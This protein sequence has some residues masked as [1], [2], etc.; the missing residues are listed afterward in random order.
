[1]REKGRILIV[2]DDESI[3]RSMKVIFE[4]KNYDADIVH[5]GQEAIAATKKRPYNL[6][7]I[8]IRLPDID[9]ITL[10][11][12]L[13]KMNA[14][15]GIIMITGYAS[16]ETAVDALNKGAAAYITK[17]LNMDE[18]LITVNKALEKQ[19]L[20]R[21][22]LRAEAALQEER[23]RAQ[24][25][26]D[27]AGVM[28]VSLDLDGTVT[29][30][31][32]RGCEIL[33]YDSKEI[34]GKDWFKTFIPKSLRKEVHRAFTSL[35][36]G[37][38]EPVE[39][40]ENPV[41]TKDGEER[42][43]AWHSSVLTDESG[44]IAGTLSSG[45]DV[46]ERKEAN[47]QLRVSER[48]HKRLFETSQDG[49]AY[50]DLN[51]LFVDVNQGFLNIV[52]YDR[53]ELLSMTY[54]DITPE[55]W[56]GAEV[57][58]YQT[59]IGVRGYSEEYEKEFVCKDGTVV[60]VSIK[61]WLTKDD[62]N[63][64]LHTIAVVRDITERKRAEEALRESEEWFKTIYE[65]SPIAINVFDLDGNLV[66]ANPALL[67]LV[68]VSSVEDF[69]NFNI[70]KDPN[71]PEGEVQRIRNNESAQYQ[72]VIDF[73]KV[74]EAGLYDTSKS[75]VSHVDVRMSPL[76]YGEDE[77][78]HGY[79]IQ[80]VDITDRVLAEKAVE[81]RMRELTCLLGTS[82]LASES[83]LAIDAFLKSVVELLPP[84]LFHAEITCARILLDGLAFTTSNFKETK[85][86]GVTDI[87]VG[88]ER[89]G[90]I[91]V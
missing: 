59:Q 23:D 16:M 66:H 63:R 81:T 5:S 8:D 76:K 22:K 84:A 20:T 75:G 79:M 74:K 42:I 29:L 26:L 28:I 31:N 52:G 1:M 6:A 44:M 90:A 60:P 47:E 71:L 43:I 21:A 17:P 36:K 78:L 38:I 39:C 46:T 87:I 3:C 34:I 9:G 13:S 64:P 65:E 70:F 50:T 41:L 37:D 67:N 73:A 15:L 45:E 48:K 11:E 61:T 51:G 85:W 91:E 49:I 53:E 68:G 4:A 35:M 54:L 2:D 72:S 7:I 25:Y 86:K 12:Q 32:R 88:K 57:E 82:Q 19:R 55:K 69:K 56:A 24:K 58:I 10:L 33:G 83:E 80:M 14:D 27:I 40:F 18:V 89:R 77:S 62:E 30:V